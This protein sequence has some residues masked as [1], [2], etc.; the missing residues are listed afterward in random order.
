MK[1]LTISAMILM[2]A[3]FATDM[4]AKIR[5]GLGVHF[6]TVSAN[7]FSYRQFSGKHGFQGTLGAITYDKDEPYVNTEYWT[8][9]FGP[10]SINVFHDERET[11]INVG[12]NYLYSLA[13]NPS[14]RFYVFGGGAYL[15]SI[16]K[17]TNAHYTE[18]SGNS[19]HYIIDPNLTIINDKDY[20]HSFYL[21][22]GLGFELNIG[23]GF[24]WALEL[25]LTVNEDTEFTMYIP[26]TGLYY[27]FH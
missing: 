8:D 7:G 26:Q 3:F 18:D 4:D 16:V 6:G 1:Q 22:G 13:D 19:G 17:G 27:Y 2:L 5:Q 14:G 20:R 10:E 12:L 24:R 21:G 15:L 25:P 9:S 23:R 11:N